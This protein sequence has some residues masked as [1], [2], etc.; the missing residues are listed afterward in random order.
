MFDCGTLDRS[1]LIRMTNE[2]TWEVLV[3]F[4]DSRY[5]LWGTW[6]DFLAKRDI[7]NCQ[8]HKREGE[9]SQLKTIVLFITLE[10]DEIHQRI[11]EVC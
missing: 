6:V 4:S 2:D 10:D 3:G 1:A 5:A 8:K 7:E 11:W 9:G